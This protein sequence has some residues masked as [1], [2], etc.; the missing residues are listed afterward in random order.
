MIERGA[1]PD[2][3]SYNAILALHCKIQEVNKALRLLSRIDRDSCLPDRHTYNMLLKMLI[4]ICRFDRVIEVWESMEKRG[5][6]PS[7]S[8]YAVIVHGLC[9]KKG[10]IEEA[11]RYF[12]MMV[13]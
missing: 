13:E 8:S 11:C 9:R 2:T 3:W 6:F 7:A 4:G 10:K 1:K 12:E 5:F